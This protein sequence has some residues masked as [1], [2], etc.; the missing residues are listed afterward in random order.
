MRTLA[1]LLLLVT[2]SLHAQTQ[3][4]SVRDSGLVSGTR[5]RFW[6]ASESRW[7][8]GIVARIFPQAGVSCL[9]VMSDELRGWVSVQTIDSLQVDR[10]A[11]PAGPPRRGQAAPSR[12]VRWRPVPVPPLRVHERG[13]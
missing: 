4:L 11:R 1:L 7:I 10:L 12:A 3:A 6:R 8:E 2:G 9:G 5:A 13:C